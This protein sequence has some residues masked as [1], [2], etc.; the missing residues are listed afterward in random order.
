MNI[1]EHEK[2]YKE[3]FEHVKRAIEEG[4][5]ANQRNIGFNVSQGAVE[6]FAIYLHKLKVIQGSGDQFDHRVFRS[7]QFVVKRV[8][9]EFPG[10][11]EIL[12]FMAEIERERN[13]LCYGS[14]KPK[15]RI[16]KTVKTFHRLRGLIN[17]RLKDASRNQQK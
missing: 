5:E 2:A 17:R 15:A 8:P 14:R 10:K 6:L 9:W 16:E 7:K 3:H 13:V 1:E 4:I 11:E 12:A